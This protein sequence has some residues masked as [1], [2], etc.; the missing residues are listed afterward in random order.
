MTHTKM[1]HMWKSLIAAALLIIGWLTPASAAVAIDIDG[2]LSF[3]FTR[4]APGVTAYLYNNANT[5]VNGVSN[6][7]VVAVVIQEDGA[8]AITGMTA[9]WDTA[10][11]GGTN[12]SFP[13][14]N[15]ATNSTQSIWIFGLLNPSVN[16][17][18]TDQRIQFNWTNTAQVSICITSLSGVNQ[19]NNATAFTGFNSATNA[20]PISVNVTGTTGSIQVAGFLAGTNFTST[21]NTQ[22][23]IDNGGNFWAGA[24]NRAAGTGTVTMT[25]NPGNV[26]TS[27]A[28]GLN[29]VQAG[30]AVTATPMRTLL[31]VGP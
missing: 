6:S 5:V 26:T 24:F 19:T 8:S 14:I 2:C 23:V 31:G 11:A 9:T 25:G 7:A 30:G 22:Q 28:A 17:N 13:L 10:P 15:S 12:T 27:L 21:N 20:A 29:V 16:P 3:G 1:I 18:P 4:S